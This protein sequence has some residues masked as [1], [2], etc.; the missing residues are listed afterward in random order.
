MFFSAL[1]FI[2]AF[3][4][5][6]TGLS[7]DDKY[8]FSDLTLEGMDEEILK[9]R[10]PFA[11]ISTPKDLFDLEP[12]TYQDRTCAPK[13][14]RVT[15]LASLDSDNERPQIFISGEIHGDERVVISSIE[16]ISMLIFLDSKVYSIIFPGTTFIISNSST[17][18]LVGNVR[19]RKK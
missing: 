1:I 19:N 4:G 6:A 17:F 14:I 15:H 13:I 18:S 5:I 8:Q 10:G 2:G 7:Q 9:L 12:A 11:T 16:Q 3:L